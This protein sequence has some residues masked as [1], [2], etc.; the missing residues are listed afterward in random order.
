M[1]VDLTE[2]ELNYIKWNL[3]A[4]R[5][6]KGMKLPHDVV[7][8]QDEWMQPFINKIY[9]AIERTKLATSLEKTTKKNT[10]TSS[11]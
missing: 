10:Q 1:D 8:W 2:K 11:N 5:M 4:N 6:Y 9:D 7:L 3:R